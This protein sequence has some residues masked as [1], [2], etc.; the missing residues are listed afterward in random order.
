MSSPKDPDAELQA[1]LAGFVDAEIA[2]YGLPAPAARPELRLEAAGRGVMLSPPDQDEVGNAATIRFMAPGLSGQR[3]SG[4]LLITDAMGG[5]VSQDMGTSRFGIPVEGDA[6]PVCERPPADPRRW[7]AVRKPGAEPSLD[8]AA[9]VFVGR[10]VVEVFTDHLGWRLVLEKGERP[11]PR[12]YIDVFD[13]LYF[14][15]HG[16]GQPTKPVER[17]A[18]SSIEELSTDA[19]ILKIAFSGGCSIA[20]HPDETY[21]SWQLV[22]ADIGLWVCLPGGALAAFSFVR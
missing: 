22:A 3:S 10:R 20:A 8:S 7:L 9:C 15:W 11:E 18:G 5:Y 2:A 17:V 14:T 6:V 19:G 1:E 13:P 16:G 4:Y 21:E 12:V